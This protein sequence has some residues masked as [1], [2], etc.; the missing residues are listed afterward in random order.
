MRAVT[1]AEVRFG[2]ELVA[3]AGHHAE[4]NDWLALKVRPMFEQRAS[5]RSVRNIRSR[6]PT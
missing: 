4:L 2:I 3:D 1:L 6:N 5:C